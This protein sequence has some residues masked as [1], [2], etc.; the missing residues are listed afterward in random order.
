MY[1]GKHLL[2]DCRNV[3]REICLDDRFLLIA[4]AEAAEQAGATVI[5]QIRY[6]FGSESPPG[7]TAIVMLDESHCSAHTYADQGLVALDFFTCGTTD[8]WRVWRL[9]EAK[10]PGVEATVREVDRFTPAGEPAR[11]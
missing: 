11:V 3:P 1:K 10:L 9:I 7:C 6:K 8:P 2:V 4:L 5:S